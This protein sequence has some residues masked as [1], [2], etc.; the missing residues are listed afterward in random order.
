M[1]V[2]LSN[3]QNNSRMHSAATQSIDLVAVSHRSRSQNLVKI[4]DL[5]CEKTHSKKTNQPL[6]EVE[7]RGTYHHH[8]HHDS[9]R[10]TVLVWRRCFGSN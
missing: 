6:L 5:D 1:S 7:I 9:E 4:R 2:V 10:F 3:P 8:Y